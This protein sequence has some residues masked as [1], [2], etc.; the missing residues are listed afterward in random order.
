[1]P[2]TK[3]PDRILG[4]NLLFTLDQAVAHLNHGS[5]GAVPTPVQRAQQR[6]RDEMESSPDRFFTLG[7]TDRLAHARNH[8]G[9]AFGIE[10]DGAAL[11]PNAT[12]AASIVLHSLQLQ[13]GDEIVTTNHGYGGVAIAVARACRDAGAVHR[14][15]QLPLSPTDAAVVDAVR[16]AL[17]SRTRLVIVDRITSATARLMPAAE[18]A[19]AVRPAG[20]PVLV[21]AAHVPGN[22]PGEAP[23]G[24]FWVG[25]LHKWA[26]APRGT[27]LFAVA[28]AWRPRIRPLVV[29]WQEPVGFPWS[30][31]WT[32]TDD[33]TSWLAAPVGLFALR[34]I[35]ADT[36][37]DHNVRLAAY[38][39]QVLAEALGVRP[40]DLP[41]PGGELPMRLLPLPDGLVRDHDSAARLRARLADDLSTEVAIMPFEG[42]GYLRISAQVYNRAPEYERLAE[43][44]PGFLA[45]L[46][47]E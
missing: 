28:S 39:Q 36:V 16:G 37:R 20:V 45:R 34:S 1:V 10:P 19:E 33:Y 7:L 27:A 43:R 13:A 24:D 46:Q 31:E 41:A 25:N 42:Q 11:V 47:R 26:F 44:L 14:V 5:H 21:D 8:L 29:S 6:L 32:G 17:S 4:A 30:L 22:R 15:V 38:G 12:T 23:V 9:A 2:A 18:V 35:G 40:A 3:P